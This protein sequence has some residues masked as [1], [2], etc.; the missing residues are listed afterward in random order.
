MPK[1]PDVMLDIETAGRNRDALVIAIG[2]VEFDA[3]SGLMGPGF[4]V[5]FDAEDAQRTGGVIDMSTIKWWMQ[6]APAVQNQMFNGTLGV[7][8]GLKDF[9]MWYKQINPQ[10][11]WANGTTFD[12]SIL[13]D[14]FLRVDMRHPWHYRDVRD[15]RMC[16]DL[17]DSAYQNNVH[18]IYLQNTSQHDAVADA[19]T[20]ARVV[21]A[22]YNTLGLGGGA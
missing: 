20:Q 19:I 10:R 1:F 18:D 17:K 11:V 13:E 5:I 16:R 3:Y 7:R 12:I 6:Q 14:L 22:Y 21:Q 9:L 15:M 4:E 8:Q 2:A